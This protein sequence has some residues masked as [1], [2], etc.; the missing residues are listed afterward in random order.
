[1]ASAAAAPLALTGQMLMYLSLAAAASVS[2]PNSHQGMVSAVLGDTAQLPCNF[3]SP[4]G[5]PAHKA[6]VV[7]QKQEDEEEL[8]VHF[9]NGRENGDSQHRNYR[10]RTFIRQDWFQQGDGG[11]ELKQVKGEDDGIYI[12]WVTLLPLGPHTQH[13]CCE[14]VLTVISRTMADAP[15]VS[16]SAPGDHVTVWII[17][18][19]SVFLLMFLPVVLTHL[20]TY[21]Q[22][23]R[24]SYGSL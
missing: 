18:I 21:S 2:C 5:H 11:V 1:M 17:F 20:N 24:S 15:D 16:V 13:R 12:C 14:V 9:Q 7:W 6:K 22:T 23:H 10:N 4:A 8:V 3:S 19:G